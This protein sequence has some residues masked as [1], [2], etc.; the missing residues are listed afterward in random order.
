MRRFAI[1]LDEADNVNPLGCDYGKIVISRRL[2]DNV[3]TAQE[4]D[5]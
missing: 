2:Q 5:T 3:S 1:E 4:R